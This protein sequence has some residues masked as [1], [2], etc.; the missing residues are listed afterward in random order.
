LTD[1]VNSKKYVVSYD[2]NK[3]EFVLADHPELSAGLSLV[4]NHEIHFDRSALAGLDTMVEYKFPTS[5]N[6]EV[7]R[8][9]KRKEILVES[10]RNLI[11]SCRKIILFMKK[12]YHPLSFLNHLHYKH[13]QNMVC[14]L[15]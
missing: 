5:F 8:K 12:S 1:T 9:L 4:G 13:I 15:F 10:F 7:Y 11:F 3:K 2:L 6:I 14:L